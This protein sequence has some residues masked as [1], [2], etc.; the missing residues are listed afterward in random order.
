MSGTF[1]SIRLLPSVYDKSN[2]MLL[3]ERL[4]P[5]RNHDQRLPLPEEDRQGKG[6]G[7]LH[8]EDG[9]VRPPH[10]GQ[11]AVHQDV[12]PVRADRPGELAVL[13]AGLEAGAEAGQG[14]RHELAGAAE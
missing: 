8:R 14:G 7:H 6:Q 12:Q 3:Q 10:D 1:L 11:Q 13:R 5:N 9:R 2:D 4:L